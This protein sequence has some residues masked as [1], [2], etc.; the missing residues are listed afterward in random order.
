MRALKN[1]GCVVTGGGA[2]GDGFEAQVE[3]LG[4]PFVDLPVDKRGVN[5]I[6]DLKL[7]WA[8][9][10]W[11]ARERPDI[12]HH[13]TI[14]PVIYGSVAARLAKIPKIVNTITGLGFVFTG[15]EITWLGRMVVL[16]YRLSMRCAHVIFFQ[17][18]DDLDFFLTL[19]LVRPDKARMVRGSGVDCEHFAPHLQAE[20]GDGRPLTFLM[21]G[22]LLR[23]KGVYEF[24][25]AARAVKKRFPDTRFQLLGRRDTRNPTVVPTSDLAL[26]QSQG[27]VAWLGEV[28]DVRPVIARADVV[29]LP[30][31]YREGIPRSLLEAAAMGRP[32]ITTNST[33]CREAVDHLA[34]GLLVPVK[35]AGALAEAMIWM[36]NHPE[37]RIDMGKA[38]RSKVVHEF[39]ETVVLGN[40]LE[41]YEQR[42]Y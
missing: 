40:I 39:D 3:A 23:D 24:V 21:V 25:E 28:R 42:T 12:V 5:P 9:Y 19:G 15:A 8:L 7:F 30:S 18:R 27:V 29:V 22:R 35:D 6:A 20:Q 34:N 10:R 11:Y 36:I 2:G 33:G 4:V 26:W 41:A 31:Y 16:L 37:K 32:L 38:G 17:N 1:R 13:F 14:K